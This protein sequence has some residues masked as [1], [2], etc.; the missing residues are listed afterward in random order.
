MSQPGNFTWKKPKIP[1]GKHYNK[2]AAK[3][4]VSLYF[5]KKI[6]ERAR[7]H[8]LNLSRITEQALNSISDYLETQKAT[9]SSKFSSEGSFLRG[10]SVPRWP[11]PVGHRLGKA[12]VAGSN[13]ARGFFLDQCLRLF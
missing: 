1:R 10:S 11:S 13:P 3:T 12:V 9:E 5:S 2:T 4:T 8:G 6:V 7:K